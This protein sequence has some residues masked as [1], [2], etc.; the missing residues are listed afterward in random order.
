MASC[1]T[2]TSSR[3]TGRLPTS[4]VI[5]R[6][7]PAARASDR[8]QTGTGVV[9]TGGMKRPPDPRLE[10]RRTVRRGERTTEVRVITYPG[11]KRGR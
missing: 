3:P 11:G 8:L 7:A 4:F 2:T 1:P 6:L 5:S 10:T 9:D